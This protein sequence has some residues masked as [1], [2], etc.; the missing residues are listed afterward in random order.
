MVQL[1]SQGK[2]LGLAGKE[3][4]NSISDLQAK[5]QDERREKREGEVEKQSL[6]TPQRRLAAEAEQRRLEAE[7]KENGG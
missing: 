1:I 3:R 7:S 5:E 6:E 4:L 2:K